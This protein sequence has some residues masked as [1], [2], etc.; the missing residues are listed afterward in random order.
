MDKKK[1]PRQ[2]ARTVDGEPSSAYFFDNTASANEFTGSVPT[3]PPTDEDA[4]SYFDLLGVPVTSADGGEKKRRIRRK[5][6]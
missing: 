1:N 3:P 2:T 5:R 6:K 4:E